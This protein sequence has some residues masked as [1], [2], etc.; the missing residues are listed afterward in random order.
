VVLVLVVAAV[1]VVLA[2]V[3]EDP[4]VEDYQAE[5]VQVE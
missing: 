4:V 3:L 2:E 1:F 5:V